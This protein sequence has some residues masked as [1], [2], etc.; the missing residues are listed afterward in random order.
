MAE[1]SRQKRIAG[2]IMHEFKH[3]ELKSGR[4]KNAGKVK[5]RRQAIAIALQEAGASK[6]DGAKRNRRNLRRTGKIEAHGRTAQQ[7]RE[8]KT[9]IGA[10]RNRESTRAMA[11]RNARKPTAGGRAA[12]ARA[13][14]TDGHTRH[15]LYDKAKRRRVEG[16]SRMTK[17]QLENAL[18]IR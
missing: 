14:R 16:R 9:H 18:G 15:E 4:G 1:T 2:R 3:G 17:W 7:E 10:D 11:R 6:Y 5:N 12:V 8:G 13:H